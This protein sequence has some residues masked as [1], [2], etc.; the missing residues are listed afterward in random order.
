MGF[1]QTAV[2]YTPDE[3][4]FLTES[5]HANLPVLIIQLFF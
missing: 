4:S 1:L 5:Q 2:Q 3:A